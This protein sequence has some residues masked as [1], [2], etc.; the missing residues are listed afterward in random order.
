MPTEFDDNAFTPYS[1][2]TQPWLIEVGDFH[3]DGNYIMYPDGS[4]TTLNRIFES[5]GSP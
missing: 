4:I 5:G 3:G 1:W 2:S